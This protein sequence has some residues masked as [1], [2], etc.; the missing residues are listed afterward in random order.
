MAT[1]VREL[2]IKLG[3]NVKD[4]P[5]DRAKKSMGELTKLTR[6]LGLALTGQ[7]LGIGLFFRNIGQFEQ[8]EIAFETLIQNADLAKETLAD[9]QEFA[10]KTPFQFTG[11]AE[12]SKRLLAFGF[13]ANELIETMRQLGNI[14]AGVGRDKLP[15]LIL[16]LGQVRA[17]TRLRGQ[18]LRQFTEA[19][20]PLIE[21][22]AKVKGL[23]EKAIQQVI[24]QGKISFQDV[25]Q[26]LKNLTSEGGRFN[27][28]MD[29]QS[30]TLLGIFSNI[31][32][33]IQ[34]TAIE[35]GKRGL[36]GEAKTFLN[37]LMEFMETNKEEIIDASQAAI[38]LLITSFKQLSKVLIAAGRVLKGLS[39]IFGGVENSIKLVI[40]AMSLFVGLKMAFHFGLVAQSLIEFAFFAKKAGDASLIAQAKMLLL[41]LAITAIIAAIALLVEDIVAFSQGRESLFGKFL[42]FFDSMFNRLEDRAGGLKLVFVK[43]VAAILTPVRIALAAIEN[44]IQAVSLVKDIFKGKAGF[45]DVFQ[46]LKDIALRQFGVFAAPFTAGNLGEGLGLDNLPQI[47]GIVGQGA[48]LSRQATTAQAQAPKEVKLN[49]NVEGMP[50]DMAS[51]IATDAVQNTLGTV[52]RETVRTSGPQVER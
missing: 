50:S 31:V 38:S 26:A 29:R 13:Q 28:L 51:K 36:L 20:V 15:Q 44:L 4:K 8:T 3:F 40:T 45:S 30:R 35:V 39:N 5:L 32:D 46:T 7:A 24:S 2:A 17:A 6:N 23:P 21:E 41:P 34:I 22:L 11:L 49:V 1:T 27:N 33:R 48:A 12:S 9:L 19:G 47:R 10:A 42:E 14:S 18:E 16:A 52:F 37:D 25:Q 43:I